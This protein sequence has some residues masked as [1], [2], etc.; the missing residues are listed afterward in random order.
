MARRSKDRGPAFL[1]GLSRS[2]IPGFPR[3]RSSAFRCAQCSACLQRELKR[4]SGVVKTIPSSGP[5][6]FA[7]VFGDRVSQWLS[8]RLSELGYKRPTR[9]QR[10]ALPSILPPLSDTAV[11]SN[12]TVLG[13]DAVLHAET[14]S[15]KS[16]AYLLPVLVSIRAERAS[17]QALILVPT[18]EL[19]LELY[20]VLRRLSVA[21]PQK[22]R[23]H[24]VLSSGMRAKSAFR[25][26]A[27]RALVGIVREVVKLYEENALRIDLVRILVVDEFGSILANASLTARLQKLLSVKPREGRQTLLV[28]SPVPQHKHILKKDV[29]HRWTRAP[30]RIVGVSSERQR[31]H[32]V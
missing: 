1:S 17:T 24:Q 16:I 26:A 27:P 21:H 3:D 5:N 2:F 23:V 15:G 22:V 31:D 8:E 12:H 30:L 13:N 6:T 19:C 28:S 20:K 32:K 11:S 25:E 7:S 10:R 29:A 14:G 9:I 18:A 4:E